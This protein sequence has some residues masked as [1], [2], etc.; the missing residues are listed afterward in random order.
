MVGLQQRVVFIQRALGILLL[1]ETNTVKEV[2]LPRMA[3]QSLIS[4]DPSG[5]NRIGLPN[6]GG[7]V[8]LPDSVGEEKDH[9][10]VFLSSVFSLS[11][12]SGYIFL[13]NTKQKARLTQGLLE[14]NVYTMPSLKIWTPDTQKVNLKIL[15]KKL[16]V[17][18]LDPHSAIEACWSHP[19]P[20]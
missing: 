9:Q 7:N 18:R 3:K 1:T 14:E 19:G 8:L 16:R 4:S 15:F 13:Q 6:H 11:S 2:L 17:S 10:P 20:G 12:I 5:D